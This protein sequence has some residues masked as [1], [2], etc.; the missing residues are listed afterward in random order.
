MVAHARSHN[1][2]PRSAP[3]RV[4]KGDTVLIQVGKDRGKT[5][6]VL[7]MLPRDRRLIVDGLNLVKKHIRPRR[8]GEK[9][10]VVE[11]PSPMPIARVLVVCPSCTKATRVGIRRTSGTRE[12]VCKKCSSVLP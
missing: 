2:V 8:A 6:K 4:K 9:G 11:I 10:Q 1:A 12:R 5:G 3:P 7:T